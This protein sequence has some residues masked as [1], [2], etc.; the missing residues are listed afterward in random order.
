MTAQIHLTNKQLSTTEVMRIL[1]AKNKALD[2]RRIAELNL[3]QY[4]FE[5]KKPTTKSVN[6]ITSIATII[7]FINL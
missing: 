5:E 6:Y 2:Q 3:C 4:S 7:R 1:G